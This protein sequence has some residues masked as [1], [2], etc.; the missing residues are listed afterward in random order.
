MGKNFLMLVATALLIIASGCSG[1]RI[2]NLPEQWK[3][4]KTDRGEVTRTVTTKGEDGKVVGEV[5]TTDRWNK[6][7]TTTRPYQWQD[8]GGYGGYGYYR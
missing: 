6:Q 4:V 7:Q 2:S 5:I 1:V 3:E 8:W